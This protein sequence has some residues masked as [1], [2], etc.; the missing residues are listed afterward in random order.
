[1]FGPLMHAVKWLQAETVIY[2]PCTGTIE[3]RSSAIADKPRNAGLYSC[4]G[5]A[6]L[7][8]RIRRQEVHVHML[9][10]VN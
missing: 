7:F 9:Q 6:G 5:M 10:M 8:L 3:T 1:M 4:R 2:I